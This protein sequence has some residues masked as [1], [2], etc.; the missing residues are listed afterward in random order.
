MSLILRKLAAKCKKDDFLVSRKPSEKFCF[1]PM[2][3]VLNLRGEI[4]F[5]EGLKL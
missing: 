1:S 2:R 3:G 4:H 5:A